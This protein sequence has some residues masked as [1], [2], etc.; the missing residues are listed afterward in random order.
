M[1]FKKENYTPK[2]ICLCV[3]FFLITNVHTITGQTHCPIRVDYE[4]REIS[5][6]RSASNIKEVKFPFFQQWT[7]LSEL[8]SSD[9]SRATVLLPSNKRS[10]LFKG[11][12][13]GFSIPNGASISGIE[14]IVEGHSSGSGFIEG[15]MIKL[16]DQ[17]GDPIGFNYA[18]KALPIDKDWAQSSDSTDFIWRYGASDDSWGLNLTEELINNAQFGYALQIRNK[19]NEPVLATIDQIQMVVY[20]TPLYEICSTHACVPFYIDESTDELITYEWYIPEGFELI[21]DSEEDAVINIGASYADYGAYEICVESFDNNSSLGTCCRTFNYSNCA[22]SLI[23]GQAFFDKNNDS[24]NNSGDTGIEALM[25]NLYNNDGSLIKS[26]FSNE[27]GNYSFSDLSPGQYYIEVIDNID[28]LV[29]TLPNIGSPDTDS[30]ITGAFGKG[31]TELINLS[32]GDSITTIGIGFNLALSL[33]DFVW[34]DLNG[35]GLQ[36]VDEP[37]IEGI[38]VVVSSSTA[39]INSTI[40]DSNGFYSFTGLPSGTYSIDFIAPPE[41]IP[42]IPNNSDAE[43]DNDYIENMP[44]NV[45]YSTGGYVDSLDAGFYRASNIGNFVWEDIN[46]NGIQDIS[47]PGI[48]N[49]TL[50]LVNINGEIVQ[51]TMSDSSGFYLFENVAPGQYQIEIQTDEKYTPTEF[52]TDGG[53]SND[54]DSDVFIQDEKLISSIINIISNTT[55]LSIDFGFVEKTA[56]LGGFTYLDANNN[57]QYD[58]D[59]EFVPEIKVLLFDENSLKIDST[60]SDFG[61]FY[62]F[63]EISAGSYYLVFELNEDLLFTSENQGDDLSDS[64]VTSSI[65]LGSTDIFNLA[66][67]EENYSI[68]AGYQKK[69]KVGDFIWLDANGNGIQDPD[70]EG[71][72]EVTIELFNDQNELVQTTV[73]SQ[74]PETGKP[75][76]YLFQSLNPGNYYIKVPEIEIYN[77]TIANETE[78]GF[79]SSITNANGDGTSATFSLIGNQCNL[80]ID[81]GYTFK[82]GNITGEVWIDGN[83]NGIQDPDDMP[84]SEVFISLY[85]E[86]GTLLSSRNTDD[87][88]QYIFSGLDAGNYYLVF[89]PTEQYRFTNPLIGTDTSLDSD[90]TND[91]ITG[92]TSIITITNGISLENIDAGLI[93]GAVDIGGISWLDR[94]GDGIQQSD[95][96]VLANVQVELYN[97]ND[98]LLATTVTNS[99]GAYSF[100]DNLAG[101]YY[102]VFSP[103]N[104]SFINTLADQGSD[105][106]F[107]DD[108]TS[109]FK[110]GS[111]DT[112]EII[113][114]QTVPS[115]NAG[116]YNLST[117]GDQVFID[118]NENGINDNEPGLN[119]VIVNVINEIGDI[120]ATDTTAQGG[121]LD[122]G[123]YLIE[124]IPPGIYTVQF[125]RPLFYQFIASDQGGD[126]NID[127]DV[128]EITNTIGTTEE[129]T[130]VSGST[131]LTVDA[132]V[133]F[134]IPMESSI[135]G[136]VWTD[137]N[138][139]G[140]RDNNE[141]PIFLTTLQLENE[142]GD[143]LDNTVSDVN[144]MYT[145]ENLS[146]GFYRVSA[147]NTG[148]KVGTFPNV[149]LDD[150]IDSDFVESSNG[151]VTETFFLSTFEDIQNVDL[152]L[153]NILN[154][155][156]F[157]WED[158]NNNGIQDENEIG[159]EEIEIT[160]TS[161]NG[162]ISETTFSN[163]EGGYQFTG[164]PAGNYEICADLPSGFNFAK[165]NTGTD[166]LDSDVDINGCTSFLDF[167]AGGTIND[168]DIGLTKNGSIEGIAF[169]DLNGNGINNLNDSGLD[170]VTVSLYNSTGELIET[171]ITSTIDDLSGIFKF[172]NLKA[173]DYYLVFQ[174]PEEYII[175]NPDIGDDIT[176]SDITGQFG[177]GST[178]LFALPSG[179][180]VTNVNGGAYLP[181]SIG[182]RVWLDQNENG[183]QEDNEEGVAGIDVIIFRSFGVPFDTTKTDINGL[184]QFN[185][186]KQGL[187]F[188]QF[189]IPQEYAISPSDQGIND[190]IDSD[191]DNTGK[192]PLISLAHGA[193][194]ESV[195][196]GIFSSMASLRS[197]VWNDINGD[198]VRQDQEARIPGI[199]ISLLD[200]QNTVIEST[201]TNSL[202]LYAFQNIQEGEY[203]IYVDITETNYSFTSMNM[204]DDDY[205]DSDIMVTGESEM[206][207]SD[208]S[209]SSLSVPNVDAGL[210]EGGGIIS[211]VW[212]D[213]NAD[214]IFNINETP[215]EGIE[216]NL[217]SIDGVH[218]QKQTSTNSYENIQFNNI[219][220]GE[221]YIKYKVNEGFVN[222]PKIGE[223]LEDNNSDV[224]NFEGTFISPV[225][226]VYPNDLVSHIDA[227]FYKGAEI[228]SKVWFDHNGN[229][230]QDEDNNVPTGIYATLYDMDDSP[231]GTR[232]V[233]QDGE[234]NFKGIAKGNY[235]IK[236]Y[237]SSNLNF[238]KNIVAETINSDVDHSNGFGTT[239]LFAVAPYQ[240]YVDIDAGI[241]Q[242]KN[243]DQKAITFKETNTDSEARNIINSESNDLYFEIHPNPA[244]NYLKFNLDHAQSEGVITIRN[245]QNQ[246][247]I[248]EKVGNMERI[249]LTTLQPGVYYVKYEL[250][251]KAVVR[252]LIK[253]Q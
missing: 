48:P 64:D 38:E 248:N 128:V 166:I 253:I 73:S 83:Q 235:Y 49:A 57:G 199:R 62:S 250:N 146:E 11:Q 61:G 34:E 190:D 237:S 229:G 37:G 79:N 136:N 24:S 65:I 69:P 214:G 100:E 56:T 109:F 17:D 74:N 90:V 127:S 238:T 180:L 9:D 13:L 44:I 113:F 154:I 188:I 45:S 223:I 236:Y 95:E 94:N 120:I 241:L 218:Y 87:D 122:S 14:I 53:V 105:D 99:N 66:P 114:F 26:T 106:N 186:L 224:T 81:A 197:I 42:T 198:G 173:T 3:Y 104:E 92:S 207:T 101:Q 58:S 169:I 147:I 32:I 18:T 184:Y 196:C 222:A 55:D 15:Q 208:V 168:L 78:I 204:E 36:Q 185:N 16:L 141:P 228:S 131:D 107:D 59:E 145:F 115:T 133:F 1:G 160:I 200:M 225:F 119:G 231:K 10:T 202:G 6:S 212:E 143:V 72:N 70:E 22:P 76:Y 232:G 41:W 43:V 102:I 8:R 158:L 195:D 77:F 167:T 240:K 152:G 239:R 35:D 39:S 67:D 251:N 118:E 71:L 155:G 151:L 153:V 162:I 171:T 221:Y 142:N 7:D 19:L 20:Y 170:G 157:V 215:F 54:L 165:S 30:D 97:L 86:N 252:K 60:L 25:I 130:I 4:P 80:D 121:G 138:T 52:Q 132:G 108:V 47:E 159:I 193:D 5:Q 211:I 175:T 244:T 150:S 129:I 243:L 28:S 126:D 103:E 93:D 144:G 201:Q 125:T 227:G 233:N 209:T 191:A 178:D 247:V 174:Y 111:T 23:S 33:G 117:I 40:T 123:Y 88:G 124:N 50:S 12:N 226:T 230:I 219:P 112:L 210:Q 82:K 179:G 181:A 189:I 187:Y 149:G 192:T 161:E 139:N 46:K 156:D 177:E 91:I 203:K 140:I 164:L 63:E 194:L 134:Q 246:L 163:A 217:Y 96:N 206:F 31:T 2:G 27:S 182:D 176:D 84:K 137:V 242:Q 135:T 249:D 205:H 234:I 216:A 75:G 29:F 85:Q 89:S 245:S 98:S 110:T 220:Q 172:T 183:I 68:S 213:E 148:G 51:N 116:Y 21:S